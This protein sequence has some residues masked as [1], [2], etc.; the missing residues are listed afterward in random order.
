MSDDL[1][2]ALREVLPGVRADLE[3]LLRIPS[4]SADRDATAQAQL[5]RSAEATAE[6]FRGVGTP[7][8]EILD[9]VEGGCP[10]VL[11]RY[12]APP[13][14]PTV[15]LYAHHDVQPTGDPAGWTS[16]PFEPTERDGR[17]Y[18][19]GAADDKAG[20]AAHLAVLRAYDGR[21][22]VGVTVFV[23][24]EEEIGS[25]TLGAFLQRYRDR[26]AADVIVL[27]DSANFEIG[28]P[29]LT[30]TLRGLADCV[31][32]VRALE[33]GVHSGLYGGAAPDALTALCRLLA[34]LHDGQGNV[35]VEGLHTAEPPRVDYPEERFRAESAM[36]DGVRLLGSGS[37]AE[38]L[39]ARPSASV[40]AID[41]TRV[42]DASNT[43]IPTA[44]A[45]V[46]VRLAPGDDA[47]KAVAALTDHL[48]RHAPWGV[49]VDVTPGDVGQ[50]VAVEARGPAFDAARTAF[51]KAYGNDPVDIGIGG[52][53]PFIAEFAAAF[54]QAAILVTSAGADP[55]CR[56]HGTDESLHLGDFAHA[57][58]AE[59][60]LL[61]EL[62]TT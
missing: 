51:R 27:A 2:E 59:A 47:R 44:R 41:T 42:A 37:I 31:V 49:Q 13:G 10:A 58:L 15:L 14:Q 38:R 22:P 24:G 45:K 57:C 34:T 30:T 40:L 39:W 21:P 17:L 7:E 33:H 46:S 4:V 32:E 26:L 56:A 28:T 29:S 11:A 53:I 52:T 3:S 23:E 16:P 36:L 54:P 5:R 62:A 20:I 61:A 55:D 25:P 50:P 48:R 1:H 18:G 8:V 35:V 19:R 60:L 9:E 43:L 12:P 6:L